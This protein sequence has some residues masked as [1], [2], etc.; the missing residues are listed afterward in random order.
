MVEINETDLVFAFPE[1]DEE[2]ILRVHF[3]PADSPRHRIRIEAGPGEPVRLSPEGPFVMH[4]Q[5][6]LAGRDCLYRSLRYPFALLVSV[7]G[8]NAI[9]GV[10]STTLDRS[11]QNYFT[12]PPQGGIDGYFQ[13]GRVHPFRAVGEEAVNQR[14]LEIRVFP[15]RTKAMA[16]FRF[17][18]RLIPG[19]SPSALRGITLLHGGERQCEPIYE[20]ICNIGSWDKDYEERVLLWIGGGSETNC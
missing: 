19:P 10:P 2:A 14:S 15:M 6:N 1:V 16:H 11:P 8:K 9:T 18:T 17:Q 13:D 5:P 7:G 4:L 3:S 20:D 12:S